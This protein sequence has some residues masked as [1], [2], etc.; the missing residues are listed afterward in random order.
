MA[1]ASP[2]IRSFNAGEVSILIEGRT[3]IDR[4]PASMRSLENYIAA[5]QGPAIPRSGTYYLNR[6]YNNAERS[7]LIP[8]VFSETDFYM[9]EFANQ[10][11]RF[12]LEDGLLTYAPVS[13][14][15]MSTG[16]FTFTAATLAANIGDEVAFSNFPEN[17]NLNGIVAKITNKVGNVYTVDIAF[18][19]LATLTSFKVARVY[20]IAS[21]YN[22][23]TIQTLQDTPSLDVVYLTNSSVPPYKLLRADTYSWSF[24]LVDF[25]DGRTVS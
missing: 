14:T 5:P 3:D 21:P 7:V 25:Q 8:F 13:V 2:I 24:Q 1:K 22:S 20:H 15:A 16:P 4:Y 11:V 9:L 10:R 23:T 6:V 12:F 17:Y 18:P 19:A